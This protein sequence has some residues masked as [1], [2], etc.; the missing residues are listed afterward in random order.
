MNYAQRQGRAR[1]RMET[2]RLDALLVSHLPNIRYLT[3]FSGSNGLL[4]LRPGQADLFT[5]GRYREQAGHEVMAARVR[6][7]PKGDLWKAAARLAAKAKRVGFEADHVTV[8]Q[9]ANW[10]RHWAGQATGFKPIQGCIEALRATKEPE[11]ISAIRRAVVLA[12]SV[13]EN[14]VKQMRP[15]MAETEAAGRLEFA[16]RQ[17]GGEGLAFDTILAGG[18]RGARVHGRPGPNPLPARGFV[19]VD[20]GVTLAGYA[21]DMTRTLHLGRAGAR[22]REVYRTV[23]AA[24]QAA[25]EAVRV[26]AAA[27][28]V[29]RAARRVIQA[30]GFG[31]AF[32]HSTGHGVGLEIHEAPRLAA[33][34][35]DILEAGQV[36]T[37]EPGIYLP[38]W[39]G[40]RI[41]DVVVVREDGADVLTPTDKTLWEI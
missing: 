35:R 4:L 5:D 40:V 20:Y 8:T 3:G 38:G 26:G 2:E 9:R 28:A 34:S 32:A 10:L 15:G 22:E 33:T 13:F 11:E 14:V 17:A 24:Q 21:S 41:E 25:I 18:P 16:L 39:G 36:I 23:L 29:D 7:P 37:I 1:A 31:Q 12:S 27:A 30:A 6:V 19:V